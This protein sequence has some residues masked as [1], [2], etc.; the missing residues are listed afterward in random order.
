[1]S[2]LNRLSRR[3]P[4]APPVRPLRPKETHSTGLGEL[5]RRLCP[6]CLPGRPRP[7]CPECRGSGSGRCI[8]CDEVVTATN[9]DGDCERCIQRRRENEVNPGEVE[10]CRPNSSR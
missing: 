2:G 3:F 10:P 4:I 7:D 9:V 5:V 8:T 1:M 6:K